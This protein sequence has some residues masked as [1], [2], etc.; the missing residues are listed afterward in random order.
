[1]GHARPFLLICWAAAG[2]RDGRMICPVLQYWSVSRKRRW[3]S[4]WSVSA[5]ESG[6]RP[7]VP[8]GPGQLLRRRM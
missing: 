7:T 5:G 3:P 1:M 8:T 2:W 4:L 6:R